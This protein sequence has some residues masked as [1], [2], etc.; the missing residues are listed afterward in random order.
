VASG[1]TEERIIQVLRESSL[2]LHTEEIAERLGLARHTVSKYLQILEAKGSVE[3]R[4]LGNA[5]LWREPSSVLRCRD[6][7]LEDLPQI[8]Q[9]EATVEQI[10]QFN[11][12]ERLTY[13]EEAARSAIERDG[14]AFSLGAQIEDQLVGFIL[15]EARLWEFGRGEQIGWIK[16]I[17]V[18]P[19]YQ[20]HEIGRRLGQE[21]LDRFARAG[22]QRVRTLVNWYDGELLAYFKTLGFDL[23]KMIP[24]ERP[25]NP[26]QNNTQPK[27][28]R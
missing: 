17:A 14:S 26:N 24:L 11:G 22:V 27:E 5:K 7:T 12:H 25:L 21:L 2:E 9:L 19:R 20:G 23:L 6:L 4:R 13:L 8:L 18:A 15:G 3:L 28:K 10:A 1:Q 16:A